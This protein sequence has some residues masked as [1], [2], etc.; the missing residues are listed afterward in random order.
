MPAL[1]FIALGRQVIAKTLE[2]GSDQS[3][4]F[5]PLANAPQVVAP[6]ASF[7]M[8]K[9]R[10]R[11]K[12]NRSRATRGVI[13]SRLAAS[14]PLAGDPVHQVLGNIGDMIADSL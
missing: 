6:N 2:Q 10:K 3:K 9:A 1:G 8:P 11:A 7:W 4:L 13:G 5:E 14:K 12:E